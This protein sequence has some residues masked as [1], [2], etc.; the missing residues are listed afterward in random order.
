MNYISNLLDLN[1]DCLATRDQKQRIDTACA[2]R[3]IVLCT[4][5]TVFLRLGNAV[6]PATAGTQLI[7]NL[8]L[9]AVKN[10][11]GNISAKKII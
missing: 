6:Y 10:F 2:G 11:I 5:R 4:L 3:N 1:L 9:F 8:Q 7:I